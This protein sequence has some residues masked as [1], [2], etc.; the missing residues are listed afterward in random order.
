MLIVV[1][2][3]GNE[4]MNVNVSEHFGHAPFFAFVEVENGK[5]TSVEFNDNPFE[6]NHSQGSVPNF[7][8]QSGANVLIAGSMGQRAYEIFVENGID[9]YPYAEGT[10]KEAVASYLSGNLKSNYTG[11]RA[12]D[13]NVGCSGH[14]G[15]S[16]HNDEQ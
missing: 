8:I 11:D 5:I 13:H 14:G 6:G 3:M 9:V 10:L 16:G 7:V 1:P 12:H 15:C 4:G 2:V